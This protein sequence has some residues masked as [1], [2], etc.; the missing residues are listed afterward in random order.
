MSDTSSTLVGVASTWTSSNDRS[1][2]PMLPR[3][4]DSSTIFNRFKWSTTTINGWRI[5]SRS[6][7]SNRSTTPSSSSCASE[8]ISRVPTSD[9]LDAP[10][11]LPATILVTANPPAPSS[12]TTAMRPP[13]FLP[14]LR[15]PVV[16][17]GT[18]TAVGGPSCGEKGGGGGRN[19]PLE[20]GG[21]NG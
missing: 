4:A 7:G 15:F 21:S 8:S 3:S 6:P 19:P 1:I 17:C 14:L 12:A 11:S 20:G 10:P 13:T 9:G 2:P 18:T 5:I 16:P